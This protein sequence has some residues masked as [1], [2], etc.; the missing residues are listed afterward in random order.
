MSYPYHMNPLAA[1][2]LYVVTAVAEIAGC[3][4]IYAWLRLGKPMWWLAPGA[5]A[6]M[7][8]GYLLTLHPGPAGRIYAA[9]GAVYIAASIAWMWAAE[10][11]LPDRWDF[12]GAAVCLAGAAIIYFGPRG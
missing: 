6:L 12:L 3:Y 10:K 11:H 7:L 2:G 8:F 5:I 4:A 1:I 9:Y